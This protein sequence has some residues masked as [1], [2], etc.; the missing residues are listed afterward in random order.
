MTPSSP[1]RGAVTRTEFGHLNIGEP[2][3]DE[4]GNFPG[5]GY[6]LLAMADPSPPSLIK[7]AAVGTTAAVE[8]KI[9]VEGTDAFGEIPHSAWAL[10]GEAAICAQPP[11][12][13]LPQHASC[14]KPVSAKCEPVSA[15]TAFRPPRK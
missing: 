1:L 9:T 14:P 8:W 4:T 7:E 5:V 13:A 15:V 3:S 6:E 12:G 11:Q 10:L 2:D